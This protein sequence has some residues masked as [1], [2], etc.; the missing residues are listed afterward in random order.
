M[1]AKSPAVASWRVFDSRI[2]VRNALGA[3]PLSYQPAYLEPVGR[4]VRISVRK[5]LQ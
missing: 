4:V 3:T 2:R 5:L 1:D